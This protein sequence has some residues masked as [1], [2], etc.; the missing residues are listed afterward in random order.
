MSLARQGRD[1][2][3]ATA[4]VAQASPNVGT[5]NEGVLDDGAD[6]VPAAPPGQDDFEYAALAGN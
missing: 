3:K 4:A 6:I 5:G 2:A 1:T